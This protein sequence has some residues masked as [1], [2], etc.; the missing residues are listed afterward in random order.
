MRWP[1]GEAVS[2]VSV[3]KRDGNL[4]PRD[5]WRALWGKGCAIRRAGERHSP[6]EITSRVPDVRGVKRESL[7]PWCR[8]KG[9]SR[10]TCDIP[11][12]SGPSKRWSRRRTKDQSNLGLQ[13]KGVRTNPDQP[14]TSTA[15]HAILTRRNSGH[16][17]D[18]AAHMD[19][20]AHIPVARPPESGRSCV[21]CIH[22]AGDRHVNRRACIGG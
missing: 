5:V 12:R 4:V 13:I 18:V 9:Q 2:G 3:D 7:L 20:E 15:H 10:G 14:G 16:D 11:K 21:T 8:A 1:P 22:K 17:Q 6:Q 19:A